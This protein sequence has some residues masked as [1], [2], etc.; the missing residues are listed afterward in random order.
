MSVLNNKKLKG[1]Y[2][3]PGDKSISHRII[4][5]GSQA[6]GK[7]SV[8]NLLES[9]DVLNTVKVMRQLGSNIKKIDGKYIIFGLPPGTLFE[10]KKELNFGNSGTSIRLITGLLS[11]NNIKTKLVGDKSLSSRPMKRVTEH[12]KRIGA[13]FIL[14]KN[15]FLP[16]TIKGSANPIPLNYEISIPSAQIKSAVMLSALNTLG[17]VTIKE[18]SSTRDH[19]E[20]MLKTMNY[21][22][23]FKE[24]KEFRYITMSSDKELNS[25]NYKV[26]GDPSSAAFMIT[27]ASLKIGSKIKVKNMLYNP[28][29]I[30]F[31]LTL[32]RMGANIEIKNKR[33]VH[34]EVIAD[35]FVHQKKKLKSVVVEAN[36]VPQQIDEIPILSIAASFAKGETIFKDLK[37]LTVKESN[38]LDL[39]YQNLKKMGVDCFIKNYDLHIMG[40][41]N[42][43]AGGAKIIHNF[44]H[45]IVMSF[46]IANMICSKNN[47]IIDKSCVKTSYPQF[48]KDFNTLIK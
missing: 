10:P 1:V 3:P 43:K 34:N 28:T 8:T 29:R 22:I 25:L 5:L 35:I 27:A 32:K 13:V 37:E 15:N 2:L 47:I 38:R 16:M 30:G 44:D 45:R 18:F 6:V 17:K 14:K 36:E 41:N 19:T 21:N 12:L 26:A 40:N 9:E 7:S 4:I 24:K 39:I 31:L 33:I 20:R 46:Y 23:L 48:F 11:T 42:L